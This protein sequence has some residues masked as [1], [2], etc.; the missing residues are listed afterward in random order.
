MT[1]AFARLLELCNAAGEEKD[2]E[3]LIALPRNPC[4]AR[5]AQ[6]GKAATFEGS[7]DIQEAFEQ[8]T[9]SPARS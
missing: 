3:Q 5:Q 1:K 6:T 2:S 7:V 9:R 4:L 8:L